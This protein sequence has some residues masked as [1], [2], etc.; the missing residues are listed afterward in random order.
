M[1]FALALVAA[2]AGILDFVFAHDMERLRV[3]VRRGGVDVVAAG[4]VEDDG[5]RRAR[6]RVEFHVRL[7][8]EHAVMRLHQLVFREVIDRDHFHR[9]S[10]KERRRNRAASG[11]D[12]HV[13][14]HAAAHHFRAGPIAREGFHLLEG[15]LVVETRSGG[16]AHGGKSRA[17]HERQRE[18][19]TEDCLGKDVGFHGY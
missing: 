11:D 2:R 8:A 15:G 4:K 12:M 1:Q 17:E 3:H 14:V 5:V 16:G 18:R 6:L 9:R 13:H 7:V 19:D 10:R